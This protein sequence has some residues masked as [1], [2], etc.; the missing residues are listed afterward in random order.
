MVEEGNFSL[1]KD[2]EQEWCEET[3]LYKFKVKRV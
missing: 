3:D 2:K 1:C